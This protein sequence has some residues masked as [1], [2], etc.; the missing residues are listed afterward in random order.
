MGIEAEPGLGIIAGG[1]TLPRR[2]AEAAMRQGR[3]I[4]VIGLQG[5]TDPATV[6]GL[7]HSWVK[8]GEVGRAIGELKKAA[9]AD[10]VM[11]GPVRRPSLSELGL[12]W[13]GAQL[14]ARIGARALG[15]DGLLRAITR[16]LEEDGFRLVGADSGPISPAASK[17]PACWA[18]PMSAKP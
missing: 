10:I 7:P 14:F 4:F 2:I 12:D 17:S 16:E 11:A 6:L 1:G 9:V 13:R 15:D 3:A 8:L 18:G 5:Q